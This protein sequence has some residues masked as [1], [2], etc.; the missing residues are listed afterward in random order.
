MW[1]S[2]RT[3]LFCRCACDYVNFFLVCSPAELKLRMLLEAVCT[4]L[5]SVCVC[6]LCVSTRFKLYAWLCMCINLCISVWMWTEAVF[7]LGFEISLSEGLLVFE[8]VQ[9]DAVILID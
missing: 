7:A 6:I 1:L 5:M 8:S 3:Q 9:F 2:P 4:I